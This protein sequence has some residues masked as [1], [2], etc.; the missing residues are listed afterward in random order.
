[1][2]HKKS[3]RKEIAF[4]IISVLFSFVILSPETYGGEDF[5]SAHWERPISLQIPNHYEIFGCQYLS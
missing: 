1:M 2:W 4:I 3:M 5:L